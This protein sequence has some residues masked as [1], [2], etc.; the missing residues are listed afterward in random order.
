MAVISISISESSAQIVSGIP[1]TITLSTN[2]PA[3]I[4]YTLDGSDPTLF[5]TIY[6][7][8]ITMPTEFLS[9]TFKVFASNG[10][11]NS[12]IISETYFTNE[13]NN[14]RLPRHA[15]D[16]QAGANLPSLYP[17][18]TNPN[19]PT[20]HF[21]NP[22]NAG[23]NVNDPALPRA[24]T[25]Y[26]ANAQP[27]GET[28]QPY[29][30]QNYSIV[31][32][33]GNSIN[34]PLKVGQLPSKITVKPRADIPESSDYSSKFFDPKAFVIF[35]DAS[36]EDPAKPPMI[37]RAHFSAENHERVRTGNNFFVSGLDAPPTTGAFVRSFYNARENTMTYYYYDQIANK[38]IISKAPYQPKDPDAGALYQI[39]FSRNHKGAGMVFQWIPFARRVLF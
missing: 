33:E 22:G 1:K 25:G 17:F 39:K 16:A 32:P 14:A 9:I 27:T 8:P 30:F 29:N 10:V 11:D 35:Q 19:Q 31:Y 6:T 36:T 13:L 28:N 37:N 15:T 26:G 3:S 4:F 18:G 12:P 2:I 20:V 34:E 23:L 38:W 7:G 21:T 24:P 5:S